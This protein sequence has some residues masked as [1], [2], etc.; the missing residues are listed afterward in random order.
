MLSRHNIEDR[1]I[2]RFSSAGAAG[3][4]I[5]A[6]LMVWD[7]YANSDAMVAQLLISL[8][9]CGEACESA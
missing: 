7:L 4:D 2:E 6:G 3:Y 5:Y 8:S 1:T 9:E